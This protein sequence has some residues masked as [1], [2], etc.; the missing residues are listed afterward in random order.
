VYIDKPK[1]GTGISHSR[2]LAVFLK[3]LHVHHGEVYS[4]FVKI[5]AISGQKHPRN[6]SHKLP[7]TKALR[8]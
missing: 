6:R 1:G 4:F 2:L 7:F 5:R 3:F 8:V